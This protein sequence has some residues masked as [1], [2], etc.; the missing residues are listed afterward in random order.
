MIGWTWRRAKRVWTKLRPIAAD[1]PAVVAVR[2]REIGLPDLDGVIDLLTKGYWRSPRSYWMNVIER[3]T[4]HQTP[5]GYPRYGYLVENDGTLVG[6]ILTIFTARVAEGVTSVWCCGSSYYVEPQF[7][8]YGPTMMKKAHRFREV[9]Y[10][11]ISPSPHTWDM[12]AA[13]GFKRL[14]KGVYAALPALCPALPGT[15]VRIIKEYD[16]RLTPFEADLLER[17]AGFGC[18]SVVCE[19]NG[20]LHPFVFVVRRRYGWPFAYL[21]YSPDQAD[22]RVFAGTLGRFLA[23]RGIPSVVFDADGPVDGIPGKY[24]ESLPRF[25]KGNERPRLGD[26]AYTEIPMFGVI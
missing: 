20:M 10:F 19:H 4:K 8:L 23:K 1:K 11:S 15:R 24:L 14:N 6:V 21:V 12:L 9:T 5:Q 18:I 25:W 17:H 22:F 3:L 26:L 2:V 7:R 16:A 13:Q